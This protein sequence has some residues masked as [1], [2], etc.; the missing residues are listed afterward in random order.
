MYIDFKDARGSDLVVGNV[1]GGGDNG[2]FS[3][4]PIRNLFP[5]LGNQSGFRKKLCENANG[6]TIPGEWAYI[7]LQATGDMSDWPDELDPETGI[8][9][10]Y[11][12][13]PDL[14]KDIYDTK[15]KGNVLLKDVF[16]WLHTGQYSRI[17]PFFIFKNADEESRDVQF[18]GL[19]VPGNPSIPFGEDLQRVKD[20]D[21]DD[22]NNY[23]AKFTVL[24]TSDSPITFKWLQQRITDRDGSLGIA[25]SAW[26]SFIENGLSAIDPLHNATDEEIVDEIE[27]EIDNADLDGKTKEALVK[28]RINQGI[29][30]KRLLKR[31]DH[32]CLCKVSNEEL[33]TASHIK[34]WAVCEASEKLD[35][36]N[37]LLLCPGH[38]AVFDRG[39]ISFD[40]DGKIIISENLSQVDRV[41]INVRP[42]M[43]IAL[44]EGNKRYLQYHRDHVL[45]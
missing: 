21:G 35:V 33:L 10:Y 27:E 8:L 11:G 7:A 41:F 20:K 3:D 15:Q 14:S 13:Q 19:A 5:K 38:D 25:P 24:D 45:R 31:Y 30:R 4:D 44:T 36:D 2:N 17:P 18:I 34:P 43:K 42:D 1:Y 39:F 37:G 9:T 26:R 32:C 40:D 22:L 16:D 28:I 6:K 23:V 12:D 29:F